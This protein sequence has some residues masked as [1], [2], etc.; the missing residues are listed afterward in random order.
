MENRSNSLSSP[1]HLLPPLHRPCLP[2]L[3][4]MHCC[5]LTGCNR[6][7]GQFSVSA[8]FRSEELQSRGCN[9]QA[10]AA[11]DSPKDLTAATSSSLT[12][13][14]VSSFPSCRTASTFFVGLS[15]FNSPR[16]FRTLAREPIR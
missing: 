9:I 2:P 8:L 12:S 6:T 7:Y 14:T 3:P 5:P 16:R 4:E 10:V 13:K 15:S 11:D 1:R